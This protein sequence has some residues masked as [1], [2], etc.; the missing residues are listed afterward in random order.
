MA[1]QSLTYIPQSQKERLEIYKKCQSDPLYFVENYCVI[2]SE[3]KRTLFKLYDFQKPILYQLTIKREKVIINKARQMGLSTLM[4]AIITWLILFKP[5]QEIVVI[6]EKDSKAKGLMR[7]VIMMVDNIPRFLNLEPIVKNAHSIRLSNNSACTSE[8]RSPNAARSETLTFLVIDEAA[9]IPENIAV[10]IYD[11]AMPTLDTTDGNCCILSTPKGLGGW[12]YMMWDGAETGMN[13]FM[14]IFLHWNLH[15]KRD[16]VWK[17]Q[18]IKDM[19]NNIKKFQQEYEG[20]FL[21]SGDTLIDVKWLLETTKDTIQEPIRRDGPSNNIWVWKEPIPDMKYILTGDPARGD[22]NDF[23][24]M[25]I[26]EQKTLDQCV[27]FRGKCST[28]EF[29]QIIHS[30]SHYYN[31]CGVSVENNGVGWAVIQELLRI[32]QINLIYTHGQKILIDPTK[33]KR[34]SGGGKTVPGFSMSS[35]LRPLCIEALQ[36][37]LLDGN[38]PIKSIRLVSELK[39]FQYVNG[40]YEAADSNC[41]D[42]LV[43]AL[44]QLFYVYE[45]YVLASERAKVKYAAMLR[46]MSS[47]KTEL[48]QES[49]AKVPSFTYLNND[50]NS[51]NGPPQILKPISANAQRLFKEKYLKQIGGVK[52]VYFDQSDYLK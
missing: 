37:Y 14:P 43:M 22:A 38:F 29:A 33:T 10:Q 19:N 11:S 31:N 42:D 16:E 39:T 40:R 18:K 25:H 27:E 8:A 51:S 2:V 52:N 46:A 36:R 50:N 23:H 45:T 32:G 44:A 9:F 15:P 21:I 24:A 26:V 5:N 30:Y 47:R 41:H 49:N 34:D 13:S 48:N 6:S 35:S 12:Y 17:A 3:M 1:R 28:L 4:A 7:K 20:D